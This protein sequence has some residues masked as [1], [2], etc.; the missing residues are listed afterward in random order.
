MQPRVIIHNVV[1]VDGRIDHIRPNVGLYY[2]LAGTWEAD[3]ILCGSNT[4][5]AAFAQGNAEVQEGEEEAGER[6]GPLLAVVDSRGRLHCWSALRRQPYWRDAIALCS[7]ATPQSYLDELQAQR[8]A[9]I[10]TGNERVDLRAALEQLN[11]RYNVRTVRVDSGGTL[12]GA[13]L[14]AGLVDEVS[15][16]LDPS[17]VGGSSP[18]SLY[19]APDLVSE[20]GVIR[21]RPVHVETLR[22]G[23]VWLRYEVVR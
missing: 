18:R 1:S 3:A 4:I 17:L 6:S 23:N 12:N 13:L 19:V 22:G 10:I 11:A 21:L 16:L 20:E 2:E 14:R 9:T 7:Q 8:V 5:L 15:V